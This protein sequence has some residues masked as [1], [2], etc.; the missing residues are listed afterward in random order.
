M[1]AGHESFS[2]LGLSGRFYK[3]VGVE[4]DEAEVEVVEEDVVSVEVGLSP[5]G[6]DKSSRGGGGGG[7]MIR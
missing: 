3:E 2:E 5:A 7:M 4:I 6:S 1:G